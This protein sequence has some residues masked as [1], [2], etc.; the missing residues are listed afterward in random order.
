MQRISHLVTLLCLVALMSCDDAR[1]EPKKRPTHV[2]ETALWV[3]GGDGGAYIE[4]SVDAKRDVDMCT[5]WNDFTGEIVESGKYRLVKENRAA[6][7]SELK[8]RFADFSG[9]I[10]LGGGLILKRQK[11]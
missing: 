4:C 2:P 11:D 3:G 6:T 8:L 7:Q 10:Y 1:L 9:L 5:V